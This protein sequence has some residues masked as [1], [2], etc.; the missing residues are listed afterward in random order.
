LQF[1]R[2][3]KFN[4]IVSGQDCLF[5]YIRGVRSRGRRVAE[6]FR[7]S[8]IL[9]RLPTGR[10]NLAGFVS[11]VW[12]QDAGRLEVRDSRSIVSEAPVNRASMEQWRIG[13]VELNSQV[14]VL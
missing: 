6:C 7:D 14:V 2:I 10:R 1:S 3:A 5:A 4:R 13:R 12:V 8:H 9:T 11:I